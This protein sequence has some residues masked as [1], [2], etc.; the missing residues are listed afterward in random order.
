MARENTEKLLTMIEEGLL[1]P[2]EVVTMCVKYMSEDDVADMM[3]CNELS[4]RFM[5]DDD[6]D[7]SM[8]GDHDSAMAS[9]GFGTDEDYGYYGEEA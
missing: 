1:D 6:Y 3:D 7:D 2:T 5:E 4:D 8:D 9:A